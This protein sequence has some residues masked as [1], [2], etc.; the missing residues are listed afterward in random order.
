MCETS[1]ALNLQAHLRLL[2]TLNLQ[3]CSLRKTFKFVVLR[4]QILPI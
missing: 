1:G 2:R 4:L 3:V